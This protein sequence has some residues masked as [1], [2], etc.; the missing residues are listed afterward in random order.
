VLLNRVLRDSDREELG[1]TIALMTDLCPET[2]SRKIPRANVQQA[3]V[4]NVVRGKSVPGTQVLAV[5][6][7]E[8][9]AAESLGKLGYVVTEVDPM[10]NE[11]LASF[12]DHADH[13]FSVIIATSV[14]EHVKD[15]EGFIR[16]ICW[17]LEPGGYAVLTCDFKNGYVVGDALPAENERFY[18]KYDLETRLGTVIWGCDCNLLD[19]PSWEGEPDFSYG[20]CSYSFATLVF[21]W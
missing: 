11:T 21:G 8:D 19:M 7:Y 5:G 3:F 10:I 2:M 15:D 18:T 20:G 1:P 6:S 17:L 14:L 9:T 16:D 13:L 12:S 4:F